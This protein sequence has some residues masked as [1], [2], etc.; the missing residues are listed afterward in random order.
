MSCNTQASRQ[1][2]QKHAQVLDQGINTVLVDPPSHAWPRQAFAALHTIT[3]FDGASVHLTSP[4]H[5]PSGRAC[6][7]PPCSAHMDTAVVRCCCTSCYVPYTSQSC[8]VYHRNMA[9]AVHW[10]CQS[11]TAVP[12]FLSLSW[13]THLPGWM[14]LQHLA[15]IT[16]PLSLK[17]VRSQ[18]LRLSK[19]KLRLQMHLKQWPKQ[20]KV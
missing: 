5:I 11:V 8:Y 16:A 2:V 15:E 13:L 14:S 17:M 19:H 10:V 12:L 18:L 9:V 20:G 1:L 3:C 7:R 4:A 6:C